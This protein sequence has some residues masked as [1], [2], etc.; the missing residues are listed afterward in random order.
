MRFAT[1]MNP[2]SRAGLAAGLAESCVFHL[3]YQARRNAIEALEDPDLGT[4]DLRRR[5]PGRVIMK[6][7]AILVRPPRGCTCFALLLSPLPF[8]QLVR[9][10]PRARF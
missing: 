10:Q 8:T 3:P 6:H 4:I 1:G 5:N 9:L 2:Q 7:V